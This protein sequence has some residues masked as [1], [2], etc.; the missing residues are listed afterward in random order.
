MAKK[1]RYEI[2]AIDG[3][4]CD[5]VCDELLA[6]A[7]D[8][9]EADRLAVEQNTLQFGAAIVDTQTGLIDY[10]AGFGKPVSDL[11]PE[12]AGGNGSARR[13]RPLRNSLRGG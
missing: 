8:L 13:A 12:E 1:Q 10:G 3:P 9:D 2:H 5:A 6:A 11:I 4:D 7:D